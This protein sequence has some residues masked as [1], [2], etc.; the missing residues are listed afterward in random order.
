MDPV[1]GHWASRPG[2]SGRSHGPPTFTHRLVIDWS[3][4]SSIILIPDGP[5]FKLFEFQDQAQL[6]SVCG[7]GAFCG[8]RAVRLVAHSASG[9]DKVKLVENSCGSETGSRVAAHLQAQCLVKLM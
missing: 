7:I 2:A 8:N 5:Q 4:R 9:R 1:R 3:F 6:H